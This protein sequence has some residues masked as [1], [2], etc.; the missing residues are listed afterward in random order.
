M[1]IGNGHSINFIGP[2]VRLGFPW[3]IEK[4]EMNG[5]KRPPTQ[6]SR[7]PRRPHENFITKAREINFSIGIVTSPARAMLLLTSE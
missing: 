6:Q 1:K 2:N 7:R 5:R 3:E 4:L